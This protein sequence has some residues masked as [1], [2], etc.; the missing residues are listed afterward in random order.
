MIRFFIANSP[1]S[2]ANAHEK[3]PQILT[4]LA[5]KMHLLMIQLAAGVVSES[6][7][8]FFSGGAPS[9]AR[10]VQEI[11]PVIDGSVIRGRV[12]AGG[13]E[14]TKETLGGPNAGR[15]VDYALLQEEG[16][17]HAW[18]I[19]PAYFASAWAVSLKKRAEAGLPQVLAFKVG[20]TQVFARRVV[21][22]PLEPHP[23]MAAELQNEES[24]IVAELQRTLN[25]VLHTP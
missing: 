9:I 21:H 5:E 23:F 19:Q 3:G 6:I 25:E 14:T 24:R 2:M 17:P 16:V 12:E 15:P 13:R 4:A 18:E 10:T 11:P 7:P 8:A 1:E 20:G 22:P